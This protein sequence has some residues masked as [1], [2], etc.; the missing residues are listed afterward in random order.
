MRTGIYSGLA[1]S[2]QVGADA[3]TTLDG[4]DW[5]IVGGESG[6]H[7]RLCDV[8][9]I[10]D[11]VAQA[12]SGNVLCFVKQLGANAQDENGAMRGR[13]SA[14]GIKHDFPA[15]LHRKGGDPAEWPADL[16]VREWPERGAR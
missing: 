7:A 4:I 10:R 11:L 13:R 9:W 16:R 6:P 8:A 3:G 1:A 5:L 2:S 14:V 12:R 15:L